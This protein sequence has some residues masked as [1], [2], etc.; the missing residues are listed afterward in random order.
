MLIVSAVQAH[1]N[2]FFLQLNLK[3]PDPGNSAPGWPRH[4]GKVGGRLSGSGAHRLERTHR[5]VAA[6]H[7]NFILGASRA[8]VTDL[9]F[10]RSLLVLQQS[11]RPPLGCPRAGQWAGLGRTRQCETTAGPG[12]T[13]LRRSGAGGPRRPGGVSPSPLGVCKQ[14]GHGSHQGGSQGVMGWVGGRETRALPISGAL[15]L[16][17]LHQRPWRF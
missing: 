13:G 7:D 11:E 6:A 1:T 10:Q 15:A 8:R 16:T 14:R 9:G 3:E 5:Q 17:L 2:C 12:F 4:G